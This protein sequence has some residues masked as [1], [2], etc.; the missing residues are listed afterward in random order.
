VGGGTYPG[1]TLPSWTVRLG[2]GGGVDRAAEALRG[3]GPPVIGRI[4]DD[5]I[6]ADFTGSSP[7][8]AKG[9]NDHGDVVG[10]AEFT[11]EPFEFRAALWRDGSIIDLGTLPGELFSAASDI[12][13]DGIIV[14]SA[15]SFL[16]PQLPARHIATTWTN[17]QIADLPGHPDFIDNE[18]FAINGSGL[19][20]GTA[21]TLSSSIGA[22][23]L[24]KDG[25]V[26]DLNDLIP[27]ESGWTLEAAKDINNAGRIV[28]TGT[29]PNG[30]SHGFLLIP[31]APGDVNRDG[32]V[33]VNDLLALLAAWG[34][35][36]QPCVDVDFDDSGGVDVLDLLTLLAHWSGAR[37]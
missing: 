10:V 19:I 28:G 27:A 3:D 26:F 2:V 14:G 4:E 20:V 22:A 24:W 31:I 12:N 29:A 34:P 18:A 8:D 33:N 36:D 6:V 35:C 7:T 25:Q 9:I 11:S 21:S 5:R 32:T 17:N 37:V 23:V 13:N 16:F 1:V 30:E 15:S